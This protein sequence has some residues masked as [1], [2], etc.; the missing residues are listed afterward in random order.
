MQSVLIEEA[1]CS[2]R[3]LQ[4]KLRGT[5]EEERKL[6]V[7]QENW[8]YHESRKTCRGKRRAM[9]AATVDASS[10]RSQSESSRAVADES[11]KDVEGEE[12]ETNPELRQNRTIG[13]ES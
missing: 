3:Q 12:R 6:E 13:E 1:R 10:G 4:N 8:Q 7:Q 5:S 11:R 2:T 9:K